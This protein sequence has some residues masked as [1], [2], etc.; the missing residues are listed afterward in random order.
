MSVKTTDDH[1]LSKF[2][3]DGDNNSLVRV[4]LSGG[5]SI[6]PL[7]KYVE[8]TYTSGDTIVTYRYYDSASKITLYTTIT[9]TYG[10]AQDTSFVSAAW[11]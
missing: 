11:S 2:A 9:V 5:Q 4:L 3:L 10:S 8:A 6:D 1:E 7:A